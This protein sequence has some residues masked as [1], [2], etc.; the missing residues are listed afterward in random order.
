MEKKMKKTIISLIVGASLAIAPSVFALTSMSADNMKA[1]TGQA[2]VG[3]TVDGVVIETYTGETLYT[4]TD[5]TDGTAA[6][7]VISD[8]H[9]VKKYD[10]ITSA[11]VYAGLMTDAGTT[12]LV[13]AD[14]LT[15]SG[16]YFQTAAA[17]TIDVGTCDIY[18]AGASYNATLAAGGTATSLTIVGVVIGLPTLCITT[19][20]DTYTVGV[21]D[22]AATAYNNDQDFIQIT[23]SDSVMAIL[24]GT[25]EI[26]PH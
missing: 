5:G 14:D 23:K 22:S 15:G 1:A 18:S 9:V 13:N 25:V 12:A 16:T 11:S 6:S 17:L 19:T 3:I 26:A 24:G 4:D 2:G 10:A 7:V 20:G 8:K 21:R